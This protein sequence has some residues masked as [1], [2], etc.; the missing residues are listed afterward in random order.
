MIRPCFGRCRNKRTDYGHL[1][2]GA[3]SG[4]PERYTRAYCGLFTETG[5]MPKKRLAK[6]R[7]TPNAAVQPGT[8]LRASHFQPGQ[9]IDL[10]GRRWGDMAAYENYNTKV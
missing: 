8:P 3:L 4:N 6:F 5:L 1:L 7:V 2:V 10:H 9:F